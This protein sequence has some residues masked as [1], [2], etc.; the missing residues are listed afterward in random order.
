MTPVFLRGR[1]VIPAVAVALWAGVKLT[2]PSTRPDETP[3]PDLAPEAAP[4]TVDVS[5]T[6]PASVKSDAS[7]SEGEKTGN[8]PLIVEKGRLVLRRD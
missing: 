6:E 4:R 2:S 5:P 7:T 3:V 1:F 8:R